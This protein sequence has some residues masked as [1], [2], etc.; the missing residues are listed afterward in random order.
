MR[1]WPGAAAVSSSGPGLASQVAGLG[2]GLEGSSVLRCRVWGSQEYNG[3][4]RN[5]GRGYVWSILCYA[6]VCSCYY[7]GFFSGFYGVFW[8]RERERDESGKSENETVA[9]VSFFVLLFWTFF[10]VLWDFLRRER[11]RNENETRREVRNQV[12]ERDRSRREGWSRS[13]LL[14]GP[15]PPFCRVEVQESQE[16]RGK[17]DEESCP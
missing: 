5:L 17:E 15:K 14:R 2:P 4:E 12:R 13:R 10:G 11:D 7:F 3:G 16:S 1:S 9:A 8:R 6:Y